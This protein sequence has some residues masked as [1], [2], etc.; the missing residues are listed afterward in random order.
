MLIYFRTWGGKSE[1]KSRKVQLTYAQKLISEFT[2]P[3][4]KVEDHTVVNEE[5]LWD[6]NKPG[7]GG[8]AECQF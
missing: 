2:E 6:V 3:A 8:N 1:Y 7:L 5:T 4:R